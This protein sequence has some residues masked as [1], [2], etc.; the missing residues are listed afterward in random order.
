M[1]PVTVRNVPEE[2]CCGDGET[3]KAPKQTIRVEGVA[4]IDER[5][6]MVIPKAIRDRMGLQ[7]GDKLAISIMESDGRPCC[8]TLIRTE[9]LAER[10][11]DI[12]GPAINDIM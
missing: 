1:Y 12:L 7:A 6:Q 2:P 8:L 5:G 4:S 9:E 10:V 3:L 11:K